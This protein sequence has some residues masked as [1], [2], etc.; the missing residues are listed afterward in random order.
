MLIDLAADA[1]AFAGIRCIIIFGSM[2]IDADITA[3][4]FFNQ[5]IGLVYTVGYFCLDDFF[6]V[7][8]CHGHIFIRGDDDAFGA[9]DFGS[10]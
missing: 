3:K 7:E 5:F 6:A 8:T 9:S 1:L 10:S 2:A 4:S